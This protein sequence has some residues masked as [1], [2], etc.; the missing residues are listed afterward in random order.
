MTPRADFH[1]CVLVTG[2]ARRIGRAIAL[3][4]AAEG[5]AVALHY[6]NSEAEAH[7]VRDELLAAGAPAVHLVQADLAQQPDRRRL[8]E[9]VLAA[10]GRL[11]ALVNSAA[12]FDYD[13]ALDATAAGLERH[14]QTNFVAPTELTLLW[15][16][17]RE[18]ENLEGAGLVVTLL[19]QKLENLNPD[20][21]TYTLSKLAAG[22]SIRFLAQTCAPWLRVNAVSP[23]VTLPSEDMADSLFQKASTV[24]AL[25]RSSRPEDI[26]QAVWSLQA[27]S[28][29]TGQTLVVDGGQHLVPRRRDVAFAEAPIRRREAA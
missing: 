11:D 9:E 16:Q 2:A 18:R 29:V 25:G 1:P 24:A 17:A 26:A 20:Y 14:L 23:G 3:R 13:T 27:M 19:D 8:I 7:R 12:A 28:A 6:R 5:W 22:A 21:C 10:A 4:Y 15:A